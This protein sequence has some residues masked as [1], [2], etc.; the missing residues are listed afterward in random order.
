MDNIDYSHA[1]Y[2]VR[3]DFTEGHRRY[4]KRLAQPG[5]WFTGAQRIDIAREVRAARDCELC[6]KRKTALSPN[7]VS[8]EHDSVTNLP[9]VVVDVIH[10]VINDN[11]RLSRHWL[12]GVIEQGLTR[13]QYIE[14][15]GTTLHVFMIDEFCRGIG[16][17]LNELPQPIDGEPNRYRPVDLIDVGAWVE[18]LP[19]EIDAGAP[20]ADL[21]GKL[22]YNVYRGLSLIPDEVRTVFDLIAIHYLADE[23]IKDFR[24]G[25]GGPL[26]RYQ[27]EVVATRI[28]SYNDC[29]YCTSGHA[30]MLQTSL[31][32]TS[33]EAVDLVGLT[34]P[35][36]KEI[37]GIPHS[38]AL[39]R[40][41]DAFMAD[42]PEALAS[43]RE[44]LVTEFGPEAM[45]D[46]A[47]IASNFQRMNRIADAT[48]LPL[49]SL[50]NNKLNA[51]R[52]SLNGQ[53][54]IDQY[55]SVI[56]KK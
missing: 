31:H 51:L 3:N 41:C 4:W 47:G 42:D 20:E 13:E 23:E 35:D 6:K 52:D 9:D 14:V 32:L 43:A 10:R 26:S 19:N 39:I 7:A 38:S 15:L 48:G 45:V 1:R 17:P 11:K 8:G 27:K 49:D 50:G 40:F 18:V 37:V 24:T 2:P 56:N 22:V 16:E 46:T 33:S 53:L 55:R 25:F 44:L 21:A 12:E 34:D 5:N 28:S 54:G 30:M 36:C 29:Y